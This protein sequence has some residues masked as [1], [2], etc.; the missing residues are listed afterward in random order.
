MF[1]SKFSRSGLSVFLALG[2]TT[3]VATPLLQAIPATAQSFPDTLQR[4]RIL[5][6]TMISVEYPE[7]EKIVVMPSETVPLTITVARDV[8]TSQGRVWIPAGAEIVGQLKPASGGSQFVANEVIISAGKRFRL[9]AN[10]EVVTRTET[11]RKGASARS[12]LGGAAI[13]AAAAT[14]IGAV[15]GDNAI[16]TEEVLGGAGLG[17]ITGIFVGRRK[18]DVV[19]VRPSEDLN[20][21]LQSDILFR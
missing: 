20:L 14:A 9:D 16:A 3:A 21:T 6:G 8:V 1:S 7:A 18:V 11:I 19:V 12:I 2:L 4:D 5:A 10:S 15:V 13:G 17:A